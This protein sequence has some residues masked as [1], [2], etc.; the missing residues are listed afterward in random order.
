MYI[1][2]GPTLNL[3]QS[4]NSRLIDWHLSASLGPVEFPFPVSIS[5]F[6]E[7]QWRR[8]YFGTL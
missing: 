3:P 2:A 1:R 4:G 6:P 8:E 7:Y 5:N